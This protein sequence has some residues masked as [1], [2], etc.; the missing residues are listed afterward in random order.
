MSLPEIDKKRQI[1]PG[2]A[3]TIVMNTGTAAHGPNAAT[4]KHQKDEKISYLIEGQGS[5][6]NNLIAVNATTGKLET[7]APLDTAT[8]I[9]KSNTEPLAL[10]N[11]KLARHA[12]GELVMLNQALA[13]NGTHIFVPS[14][15]SP[16]QWY[17]F[18][19]STIPFTTKCETDVEVIYNFDTFATGTGVHLKFYRVLD[20]ITGQV[21]RFAQ[22][23]SEAFNP[24][25]TGANYMT[26]QHG[27]FTVPAGDHDFVL[28]YTLINGGANGAGT[29]QVESTVKY[30]EY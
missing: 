11:G 3:E 1:Q 30:F 17:D 14:V 20:K 15:G 12:L 7:N 25:A 18:P 27:V 4:Y 2:V 23:H 21:Y 26:G 8:C 28:Q 29:A 24:A 13:I 5:D 19:G 6:T 16:A 22:A 10:V 9:D